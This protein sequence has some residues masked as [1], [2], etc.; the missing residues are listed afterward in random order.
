MNE[1]AMSI[2]LLATVKSLNCLLQFLV[3]KWKFAFFHQVPQ[4]EK[5]SGAEGEEDIG[6]SQELL[7]T[8]P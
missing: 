5:E 1:L 6:Y 2:I 4:V 8:I 3:C 7:W